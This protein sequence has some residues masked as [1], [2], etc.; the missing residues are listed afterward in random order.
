SYN[1]DI[2]NLSLPDP[3]L[4]EFVKTAH[5]NNVKAFISI[6]GWTSSLYFSTAVGSAENRT[7]FVKTLVDFAPGNIQTGKDR[8]GCD[9]I[10]ANDPIN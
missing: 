9:T 1:P 7:A 2:G 10:N 8:I 5:A 3:G 6:G 4:E